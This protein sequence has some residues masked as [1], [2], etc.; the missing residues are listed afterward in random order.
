MDYIFEC[1][2]INKS[3]GKKPFLK[4]ISFNVAK[5]E[6]LAVLGDNG[7]GKSTLLSILAGMSR[8]N[9]GEILFE[10][11]QI[12]R[13]LR[14]SIGYVPQEPIF[15]DYLTVRDNLNLWS[16]IYNIDNPLEI[17]PTFLKIEPML[18]KKIIHLSGGMK[19]RL[20]IAIALLNSPK[21][22]ILDEAFAALDSKTVEFLI[23]YLKK[24]DITVIYS[25]HNIFDIVELCDKLIVLKEG[26]INFNFDGGISFD[27][28]IKF[29]YS[30]F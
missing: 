25:S 27:D 16:G 12:D 10:G 20:S 18:K 28:N 13:E 6:H 7:S 1:K 5:G 14:K 29:L 15:I 19:K 9:G 23:N 24:S 2:S 11:E 30:K 21:L 26:V 17:I 3:L 8:S 4:D 22:L